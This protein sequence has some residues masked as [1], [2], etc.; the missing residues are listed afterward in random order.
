MALLHHAC[1][2]L[3]VTGQVGAGRESI[4]Y[5]LLHSYSEAAPFRHRRVFAVVA[6]LVPAGTQ[7]S[8][9]GAPGLQ[10]ER[11]ARSDLLR[12]R[13]ATVNS[14]AHGRG[15]PTLA[16]PSTGVLCTLAS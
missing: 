2:L 11:A 7:A 13:R 5:L 16:S 14:V 10:A 6:G 1:L 3:P 4:S 8:R 15:S 12:V 9:P